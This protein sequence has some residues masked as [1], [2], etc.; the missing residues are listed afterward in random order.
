MGKRGPKGD[1]LQLVWFRIAPDVLDCLRAEAKARG[2]TVSA[3][4]REL[5][6]AGLAARDRGD[7]EEAI[8]WSRN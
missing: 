2:T 6:S 3:I 5:V 7:W 8:T 1:G 4:L